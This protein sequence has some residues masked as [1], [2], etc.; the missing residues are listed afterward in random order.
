MSASSARIT[1]TASAFN[2]G[3]LDVNKVL[4][5]LRNYKFPTVPRA[6][7]Q[8]PSISELL[9][10]AADSLPT[11]APLPTLPTLPTIAPLQ[12]VKLSLP[13]LPQHLTRH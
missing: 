7:H 6:Q 4:M 5:D 12:P 2:F 3:N 8:Q 10:S 1:G 9:K 13:A 11:M